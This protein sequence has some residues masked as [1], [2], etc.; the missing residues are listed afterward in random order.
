M[1][2][3]RPTRWSDRPDPVSGAVPTVDSGPT[4]VWHYT[5][6]LIY[7]DVLGI[8]M[9]PA[10]EAALVQQAVL[11]RATKPRAR[12]IASYLVQAARGHPAAKTGSGSLL[13][14]LHWLREY[15]GELYLPAARALLRYLLRQPTIPLRNVAPVLAQVEVVQVFA[16]Q[17]ATAGPVRLAEED[18][19]LRQIGP[20]RVA[21][22]TTTRNLTA[23]AMRQGAALY[24]GVSSRGAVIKV[25]RGVAFP[26]DQARA[27]LGPGW[28]QPY[29]DLL[30]THAPARK[31]DL[32]AILNLITTLA[33]EMR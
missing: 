15:A 25:R 21:F 4:D 31:G 23:L 9:S 3:D 27:R 16:A 19:V 26:L 13:H 5:P 20:W 14:A 1:P 18:L 17:I 30:L 29:A 24:V 11:G 32:A 2:A 10:T 28:V 33:Q 22:T 6:L 12:E 7:A 8:P